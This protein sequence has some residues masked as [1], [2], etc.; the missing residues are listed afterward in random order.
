MPLIHNTLGVKRP[1]IKH[2]DLLIFPLYLLILLISDWTTDQPQRMP[3]PVKHFDFPEITER[4]TFNVI[5]GYNTLNY[6]IYKGTPQGYQ[7]EIVQELAKDLN[8]EVSISISNDLER[9]FQELA[10]GN[11]DLV[12]MDLTIKKNRYPGVCFTDSLYSMSP[13]LIQL[14]S[15]KTKA[16]Y[17]HNIEDLNGKTVYVSKA[18]Y[19]IHQL[20]TLEDSFDIDINIIEVP[21]YGTEE[22]LR[23]VAAGY[24]DYTVC[25]ENLAIINAM[26]YP[27]ID[28]N[29]KLCKPQP[30]GWAISCQANQWKDTL[31]SWLDNFRNS[32]RFHF[33]K[34]KYFNNPLLGIGVDEGFHSVES[35]RL[36]PYDKIIKKYAD[37]IDWDWRLLASLIYQE[38]RFEDNYHSYSGAFGIMQLMPVTA[39]RFN[40]YPS[41]SIDEQIKGGS[42]LLHYLDTLFTPFVSN[43]FERKKV[44][45][46]AYNLGEAHFLD[47]FALAKKYHKDISTW[48]GVLECLKCKSKPKFYTDPVV[49][50]GYVNP[51]YV[52]I[53]VRQIFERY[54][55]YKNVFKD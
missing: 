44:V 21:Q 48:K 6:F 25:D 49:K 40:V 5:L 10:F 34:I 47:A 38:S 39:A 42:K 51:W 20:E 9:A 27:Q 16:G 7:Y 55:Q 46:G 43:N 14:D 23:M 24:I 37:S 12:A 41:S 33:L 36:S 15:Q 4:G 35:K 29:L 45:I 3:D 11:C 13:I 19:F 31:N 28:L 22:L 53:F 50:F 54:E 32:Y 17:L 8:M 18:T 2:I 26:Y 52:E 1:W 30:I